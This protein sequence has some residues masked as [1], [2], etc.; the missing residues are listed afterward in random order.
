MVNQKKSREP[1]KCA[2]CTSSSSKCAV[3]KI[4]TCIYGNVCMFAL[5]QHTLLSIDYATQEL[6]SGSWGHSWRR[7]RL[8]SVAALSL[9]SVYH[10]RSHSTGKLPLVA[11]KT[12]VQYSVDR[13]AS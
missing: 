12:T 1:K 7:S 2:T 13:L 5:E 10:R 3:Q 4:L 9:S 11:P 8:F 6:K